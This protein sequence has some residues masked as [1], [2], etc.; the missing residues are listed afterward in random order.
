MNKF[1]PIYAYSKLKGVPRQNI[2][3][4]IR[5]GKIPKDKFKI[6]NVVVRRIKIREDA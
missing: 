2:Y 5:E 4:W 1:I 3:R 6:V